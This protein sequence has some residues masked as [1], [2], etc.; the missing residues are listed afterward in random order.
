MQYRVYDRQYLTY[1]DGGY[2]ASYTIDDDYIVNNNSSLTIV[3]PTMAAVG[4][5]IALIEN[6]G[7]Y[8]KGVITA[9]DNASYEISYKS[10]KELF[11]DDF[12][13]PLR[14]EF[15]TDDGETVEVAGNFGIDIVKA[16][17]ESL[18][19]KTE[20]PYKRLPLI[21]ETV[22]DVV[23]ERG[24]G[25]MSWIWDDDGINM[26]D[27]LTELFESYNVVLSWTID[28]NTSETSLEN[29]NPKIVVTLSAITNAGGIIKDNVAM[30]TIT[31]TT[32]DLP[33][34]TVCYIISS[35]TKDLIDGGVYYLCQNGGEYYVTTDISD[36]NRMRPVKS[37]VVEYDDSEDSTENTTLEEAAAN[38]L[39]PS[40]YNHSIEIEIS[41]DSKMFDFENVE[42]GDAYQ[43]IRH[44]D[45]AVE[46]M[47]LLTDEEKEELMAS[48]TIDSIYT[49]RKESSGNKII[50]L[51][52]GLGRK[53]YTDLIQIRMRKQKHTVVYNRSH[54]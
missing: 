1:K 33:D 3:R 45:E 51:Y 4:D 37:V 11:N 31:Y 49:G 10:D 34:A 29:R 28:F 5:I 36:T 54:R 23:D 20:D 19:A 42:F 17:I 38:E 15:D 12:L 22:G 2:V 13:N 44:D 9:V 32:E 52:F 35:E 50:T 16:I 8:H 53:N 18:F 48:L 21:V 39:I 30:Q 40:K 26:V 43:I 27:W 41:A 25:A 24:N 14:S 47:S 6:S 7:A 46:T